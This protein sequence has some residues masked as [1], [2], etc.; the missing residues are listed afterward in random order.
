MLCS[1]FWAPGQV[2]R[3]VAL[4]LPRLPFVCWLGKWRRWK[5]AGNCLLALVVHEAPFLSTALW[6]WLKILGIQVWKGCGGA[7]SDFS[8]HRREPGRKTG[9]SAKQPMALR[10]YQ[11][12]KK[13]KNFD[14][15][16]MS[17]MFI[18]SISFHILINLSHTYHTY[19]NLWQIQSL[20]F[21]SEE[22]EAL[23]IVTTE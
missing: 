21:A 20:H 18:T 9:F 4:W 15:N 1:H 16:S 14:G 23:F 17:W 12:L 7:F 2:P 3:W 6:F 10:T 22:I 19:T 5:G 8:W 13:K 11:T